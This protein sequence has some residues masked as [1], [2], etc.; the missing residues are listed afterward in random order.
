MQKAAR[1]AF[2]QAIKSVKAREVYD[3]RG[4]PTVEAEV[5]TGLGT[6]RAI[7]PSG[8]STGIYEALELR[9]TGSPRLSG[10][11]VT[12]AVENVNKIIGP[13]LLGKSVE[14]QEEIDRLMVE[15]LDG[16]KNEHG[17]TKS[18][19]GANSILSVSLAVAR[20]GAAAKGLPLYQHLAHLAGRDGKKFRIPVPSFN[21]I[22]GGR[23]AENKMAFQE[24]MI[25]PLGAS[26]FKQAMEMGT[27]VYHHLKKI[28][29]K[30]Y[31]K[32]NTNVGD[33]GGFA[34]NIAN[35]EDALELASEAISQAK[36]QGKVFFGLDVAASEFF[37]SKANTYNLDFKNE[38]ATPRLLDQKKMVELYRKLAEKYPIVSVEDPFDQDDAE[39]WKMFTET[40]GGKL[41]VV[42]DDLLVTNPS[43]IQMAKKN[44]LCNAL[45]LKV[46]QIGSLT[47]SI[48]ASN[49]ARDF[50]WG[51]MISHRSGETEDN[52]IG[53]L[54]VGLSTG[55]IKSGAPCRSERIAKYNQILR[56]EEELGS[57]AEYA[58]VNFKSAPP[59]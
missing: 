3:S 33:E 52:F 13:A 34:P 57:K 18:K 29:A 46:N 6:Y 27:D 36:L 20:A 15:V 35:P 37:D 45:L 47:E 59:K 8:A 58:G 10:K 14:A 9:D 25:L 16:S 50:G 41:Q 28:I 54:V 39:G 56:I 48:Q 55:Q 31:G 21:I 53:D 42:G 32:A 30:K 5:S 43:R 2:G 19:L 44:K 12:K 7:V 1:R 38:G 22:N 40:F 11:G 4:F 51:V 26:S 24:F 49:T 23:H 17:F